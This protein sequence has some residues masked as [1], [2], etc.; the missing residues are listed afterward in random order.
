MEEDG[1]RFSWE[2]LVSEI[3]C[4]SRKVGG[5]EEDGLRFSWENLVIQRI[6]SIQH[7]AGWLIL[8]VF[9]DIKVI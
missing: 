2:N 4:S 5:M 8:V 3:H 1:L 6:R 7:I 9:V